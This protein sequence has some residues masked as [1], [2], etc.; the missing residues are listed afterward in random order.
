MRAL[1]RLTFAMSVVTGGLAAAG[2][3]KHPDPGGAARQCQKALQAAAA[4]GLK[5]EALM[6]AMLEGCQTLPAEPACRKAYE[7]AAKAERKDIF[8]TLINGCRAAYCPSFQEPVPALCHADLAKE[9]P[10]ALLQDWSELTLAVMKQDLGGA[11]P[12]ELSEAMHATVD[13]MRAG[14]SAPVIVQIGLA[15]SGL[16]L[17][18]VNGR[19]PAVRQWRTEEEPDAK[20]LGELKAT[21]K[22]LA[23]GGGTVQFVVASE[24]KYRSLKAVTKVLAPE[25]YQ[26]RVGV[27]PSPEPQP[28]P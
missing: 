28:H 6:R 15:G 26:L 21:V 19:G 25:G 10:D 9:T 3:V 1:L 24:V 22:K 2:P 16:I 5:G 23:P 13:G 12:V 18:V 8:P 27:V 7:Q 11:L 4:A 14:S 17:S 20:A